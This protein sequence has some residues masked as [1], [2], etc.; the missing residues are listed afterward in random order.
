M[1]FIDLND[2]VPAVAAGTRSRALATGAEANEYDE[3]TATIP[4]LREWPEAFIAAGARHRARGREAERSG[5]TAAAVEALFAAAALFHLATCVPHPGRRG[6]REAAEAMKEGLRISEPTAT[7]ISGASFVGVLRRAPN[8][9]SAPLVIIVPGLD[10]SKEEFRYVA[11][12]LALQGLATLSI[13]G[14]GQ[15]ELA[16]SLPLRADYTPVVSEALDAID[17]L[18]NADWSPSRIGIAALSLGGF[19]GTTALAQ[20][21]RL[22][23]GLIVSGPHSFDWEQLPLP[24][25]DTLELRLG[26]VT[27]ARQFADAIDLTDMESSITQP[28][29]IVTGG[30]DIIPGV[31]PAAILT[32][33]IPSATHLFVE[34]GDHLLANAS[35]SWIPQAT[36][37]LAFRLNPEA[38]ATGARNDQ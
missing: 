22:K 19:F 35:S 8:L 36:Q 25:T 14:P 3:I 21:P 27:A 24:V 31:A 29:L 26:S 16:E 38:D 6:H 11:D 15:G 28:V 9:A 30:A 20:E 37:W 7:Y 10:S 4:S 1:K 18:R 34:D 23:A 32:D 5:D 17:D 13:D 12:A 2:I 33:R